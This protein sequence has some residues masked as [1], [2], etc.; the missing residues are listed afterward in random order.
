MKNR[1]RNLSKMDMESHEK[2]LQNRPKIIENF[3][4]STFGAVLEH[5]GDLLGAKTAQER[6]QERKQY[7]NI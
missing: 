2:S 7:K 6:P 3:I 1:P 5:F 4:K